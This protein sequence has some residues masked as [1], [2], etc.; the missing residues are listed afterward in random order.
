MIQKLLLTGVAVLALSA[1]AGLAQTS[2]KFGTDN[3]AMTIG[4]L[5]DNQALATLRTH[6][7]VSMS[8][9]FF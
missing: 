6:G 9:A 1:G 2:A 3:R 5:S 4:D 7:R 8:G